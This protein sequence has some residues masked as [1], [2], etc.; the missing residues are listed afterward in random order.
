VR[1]SVLASMP[2]TLAAENYHGRATGAVSWDAE[3]KAKI[4]LGADADVG[5]FITSMALF[6]RRMLSPEQQREAE[7]AF[8]IR[9]GI[10]RPEDEQ[11]Y[12]RAYLRWVSEGKRTDPG[13]S[14]SVRNLQHRNARDARC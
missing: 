1:L 7:R 4:S 13:A 3:G 9:D 11:A 6:F 14:G 12:A 2:G 5:T 10:W 8:G